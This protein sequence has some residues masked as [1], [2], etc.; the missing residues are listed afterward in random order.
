MDVTPILK[1]FSDRPKTYAIPFWGNIRAARDNKKCCVHELQRP[2][3]AMKKSLNRKIS[4]LFLFFSHFLLSTVLS[5]PL[6]LTL[7]DR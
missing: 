6:I 2:F 3:S 4:G 1:D 5:L 7:I